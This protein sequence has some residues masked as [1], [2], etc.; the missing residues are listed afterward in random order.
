MYVL[1]WLSL[2][3]S[4]YIVRDDENKDNQGKKLLYDQTYL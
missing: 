3:L 2:L 1:L 4:L